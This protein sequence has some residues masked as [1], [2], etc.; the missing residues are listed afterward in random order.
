[1]SSVQVDAPDE[2]A[3]L[4]KNSALYSYNS[5]DCPVCTGLFGEPTTNGRLH[6]REPTVDCHRGQKRSETVKGQVGPD[7]PVCHRTVQWQTDPTVDCYRPQ[8]SADV[9]GTGQWTVPCLVRTGLSGAPVDRK[10]LPTA[11]IMVGSINTPQPPPFN[12]SKPPTLPHSI[13]EQRINSK[14]QSKPP[15]PLQ[16][17]QLRP[18][19]NSD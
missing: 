18:V 11:I 6:C 5:S 14:T 2:Q 16:V 10:L 12:T 3:A 13:Q 15:N 17:P 19:I 4:G 9:A 7:Y 8:W 1:M